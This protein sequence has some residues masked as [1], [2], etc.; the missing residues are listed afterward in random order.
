MDRGIGEALQDKLVSGRY[1]RDQHLIK[2]EL[3]GQRYGSAISSVSHSHVAPKGEP[4]KD[5][6]YI[7]E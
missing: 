2:A 1:I 5:Y 3:L 6:E 7:F 4:A